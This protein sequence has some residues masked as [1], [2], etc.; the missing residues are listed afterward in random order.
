ML[1]HSVMGQSV[2]AC[3]W[4]EGHDGSWSWR[5]L[6]TL[7]SQSGNRGGGKCWGSAPVSFMQQRAPACG[8][9]LPALREGLPSAIK[10]L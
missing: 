8:I 1:V 10:A 6:V 2:C 4:G 3:V 5:Q 7:H 9:M